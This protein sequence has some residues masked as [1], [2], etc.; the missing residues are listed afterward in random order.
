MS[1]ARDMVYLPAELLR[2]LDDH[3]Q[4]VGTTRDDL[5]R[6]LVERGLDQEERVGK[7]IDDLLSI[8]LPPGGP[9]GT[10]MIRKFRDSR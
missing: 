6:G 3:A 2:R 4:A 7:A 1:I 5:L 9:S 8:R 10:E